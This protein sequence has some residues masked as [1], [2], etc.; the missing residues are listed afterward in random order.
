MSALRRFVRGR[1]FIVYCLF[2]VL[3]VFIKSSVFASYRVP[4]GSMKPTI[5]EGD[6][7]FA[8]KLAYRLKLPF[9]KLSVVDW[10][11]PARG[12]IIVFRHPVDGH[13]TLTKRVIGISGDVVELRGKQLYLNGDRI[14]KIPVDNDTGSRVFEE[15][16]G[17][18]K[19]NV[20]HKGFST[21]LDDMS[22]VTVPEGFVFAM[23]DNRDTSADSR[24]WGLVPVENIEGKIFFRWFSMDAQSLRPRMERIGPV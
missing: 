3:F 17:G 9:T 12:D 21:S 4:T 18:V 24:I 2:I 20:Q 19:Y 22:A 15:E 1:N 23:G 14:S 10:S 6:F 11:I 16:L 8:N 5:V 13:I 7:F